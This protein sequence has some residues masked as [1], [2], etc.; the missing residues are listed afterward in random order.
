[1]L[2]MMFI[3]D[4]SGSIS[5]SL[6]ISFGQHHE[7]LRQHVSKLTEANACWHMRNK[8]NLVGFMLKDA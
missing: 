2:C 6:F 3:V 7:T 8:T 5:T 4:F 1:M